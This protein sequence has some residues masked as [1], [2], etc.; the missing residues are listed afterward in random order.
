MH[1][2]TKVTS[3]SIVSEHSFIFVCLIFHPRGGGGGGG[4]NT[5]EIEF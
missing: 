2:P 1:I 5:D 3:K 4:G